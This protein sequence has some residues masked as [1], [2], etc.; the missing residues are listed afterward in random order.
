[1]KPLTS[2]IEDSSTLQELGRASVQ[3]VHDLRNQLNG[4][5]LY[6]TLLLKQ[7]EKNDRPANELETVGKLIAGLERA[8][9]DTA[10][11]V[12]YGRPIELR[13]QPNVVLNKIVASLKNSD[14]GAAIHLE[15]E[16]ETLAGEFDAAALTDALEA[17]TACALDMHRGEFGG[18]LSVHLRRGGNDLT[19][20]A[21]IEWRGVQPNTD[22][23][24]HSLA[25]STGLR[26]SLAR[27]ITEA[28]QGEVEQRADTLCV[29]LPIKSNDK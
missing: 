3:I 6:A 15:M 22:D 2:E 25:G 16:A 21:V 10:T 20:H 18:P 13:R 29:R 19:P 28:H 27:K 24:F 1:M 7:M 26:M 4:L 14:A 12:R 9:G 11:L 17:I 23:V 8:A 5:K